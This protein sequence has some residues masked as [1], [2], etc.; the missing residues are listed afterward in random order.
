M[1][2]AVFLQLGLVGCF[3]GREVVVGGEEVGV[4]GAEEDIFV[5][6]ECEWVVEAGKGEGGRC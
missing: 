4:L 5:L 6:E 1:I 2:S 3:A